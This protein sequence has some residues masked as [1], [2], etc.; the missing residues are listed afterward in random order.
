MSSILIAL[1][2]LGCFFPLFIA[3]YSRRLQ[4]CTGCRSP[5]AALL[6]LLETCGRNKSYCAIHLLN[7]FMFQGQSWRIIV[8]LRSAA[9]SCLTLS[10]RKLLKKMFGLLP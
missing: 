1:V 2:P 8:F 6:A 10:S 9:G 3:L 7:T 5:P 4:I